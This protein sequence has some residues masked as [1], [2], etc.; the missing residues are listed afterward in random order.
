MNSPTKHLFVAWYGFLATPV[1][2]LAI[3]QTKFSL[4]YWACRGGSSAVLPI[5]T[6]AG[7]ILT[8]LGA[9]LNYRSWKDLGSITDLT[10]AAA[11]QWTSSLLV[12]GMLMSTLCTL[13]MLAM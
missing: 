9:F 3:L 13:F 11:E 7:V 8:T 4:V 10:G 12:L 5:V 2:S 6:I 1:L